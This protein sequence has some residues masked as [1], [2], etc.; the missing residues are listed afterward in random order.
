MEMD[1]IRERDLL[2]FGVP[3]IGLRTRLGTAY[4]IPD[5]GCILRD[6]LRNATDTLFSEDRK[7]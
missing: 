6:E 1:K 3:M 4:K 2:F 5:Y 7:Q